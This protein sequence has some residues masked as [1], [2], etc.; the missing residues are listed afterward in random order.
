MPSSPGASVTVLSTATRLC[1]ARTRAQRAF[2]HIDNTS[3]KVVYIGVTNPAV[4][5]STGRPL[6][7]GESMTIVNTANDSEATGAVYAIVA[8]GT[9]GVLVTEGN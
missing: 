3:D 4:T 9:A 5:T 6:A 2:I 1:V 8:T 7:P